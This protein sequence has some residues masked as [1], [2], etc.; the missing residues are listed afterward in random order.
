MAVLTALIFLP[1]LLYAF[2]PNDDQAYVEVPTF[3][4][5]KARV[6]GGNAGA[7]AASSKA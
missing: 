2:G 4:A 7:A 6:L 5:T 3:A 1:A